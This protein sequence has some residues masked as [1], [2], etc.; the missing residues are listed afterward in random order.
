M[1]GLAEE[2]DMS[3]EEP[4]LP[5]NIHLQ[6]KVND[7]EGMDGRGWKLDQTLRPQ[8]ASALEIEIAN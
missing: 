3:L 6:V 2:I 4:P 1:L 7:D 8:N 5:R